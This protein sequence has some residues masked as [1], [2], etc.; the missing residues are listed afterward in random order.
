MRIKVDG[1][2]YGVVDDGPN[3]VDEASA[4]TTVVAD[5]NWHHVAITANRDDV[6]SVYV[7]GV[8]E[9]AVSMVHVG[10]IDVTDSL[11]IGTNDVGVGQYIGVL[12]EVKIFSG[13][14]D[15][16]EIMLLISTESSVESVGKLTT[17][18]GGIKK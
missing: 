5:G 4:S 10:N 8:L 3:K 14:L 18:W 16:N 13:V 7:D 9:V 17:V 12:D 1:L 11:F 2:I 6:E 15:E